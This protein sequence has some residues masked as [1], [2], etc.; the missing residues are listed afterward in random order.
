MNIDDVNNHGAYNLRI[1]GSVARG[2]ATP[3]S[4]I[5]ILID[6][7][8]VGISLA[9]QYRTTPWFPAGLQLELEALLVGISLAEQYRPVDIATPAMLKDRN[10]DHTALRS[11]V[12]Y[13]L[14]PQV[15]LCKG[16]SGG[17]SGCISMKSA[18]FSAKQSP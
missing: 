12:R 15:P 9:E 4:D 10:H 11:L 18:V 1:F 16:D 17:F 5:D 7:D 2:E 14:D 6:Y 3:S 8:L 13:R